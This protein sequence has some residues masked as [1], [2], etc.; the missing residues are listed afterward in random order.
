MQPARSHPRDRRG[1]GTRRK[2]E[3][4]RLVALAARANQLGREASV[5]ALA[6]LTATHLGE[7]LGRVLERE[8]PQDVASLWPVWH[9]FVG[10]ARTYR[11]RILDV[12]GAAGSA[13]A[14]VP[15]RIEADVSMRLDTRSDD[16]KD[17]DARQAWAT[18]RSRLDRL[19]DGDRSRI[20][21]AES[22]TQPLWSDR[23]PTSAG[24]RALAALRRLAEIVERE[25]R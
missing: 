19:G 5:D 14:M 15:E 3:D 21:Q 22:G 2:A 8:A 24:L 13:L 20:L 17:A 10:A 1:T 23:A 18:W 7:E 11:A 4:A 16:E 6:T 25:G 12:R 9:A